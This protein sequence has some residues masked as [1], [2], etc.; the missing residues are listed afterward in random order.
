[1]VAV[2]ALALLWLHLLRLRFPLLGQ[3]EGILLAYADLILRGG[4]PNRDFATLYPP[5]AFWTVAAAFRLFGETLEVERGVG[6]LFQIS[7][8]AAVIQIGRQFGLFASLLAGIGVCTGVALFM[9]GAYSVLGGIACG[10]WAIALADI[11]ERSGG[12]LRFF[13]CGALSALAFLYRQ[14]A[15]LA[16]IAAIAPYLVARRNWPAARQYL[17]GFGAG[18][19]PL[20]LHALQAGVGPLFR[21][22]VLD[23]LAN[24]PGRALPIELGSLYP[25]LIPQ[26]AI[27][28]CAGLVAQSGAERPGQRLALALAL[29]SLCFLPSILQRAD[30]WHIGYGSIVLLPSAAI[31]LAIVG[32]G[33]IPFRLSGLAVWPI[34]PIS[35]LAWVYLLHERPLWFILPTAQ[36]MF[37]H[38]IGRF[39]GLPLNVGRRSVLAAPED[40][41]EHAAVAA[42]L[43]RLPAGARLVVGPTDLRR[44]MS[45]DPIF[46]FL[47]PQ[48]EPPYHLEMNP[49]VSDRQG[50]RLAADVAAADYLL[51]KSG[52]PEPSAALGSP[53]PNLL[54]HK[55]FCAERTLGRY[56]LLRRCRPSS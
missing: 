40:H 20:A 18:M 49:G 54:V 38:T 15:G 34:V 45:S 48:L 50:S 53:A 25:I 12:R 13:A 16:T 35:A 17:A 30:G 46:Y 37:G 7:I 4:V 9:P 14:D 21:N 29:F 8:L 43:A 27:L 22:Y 19:L 32:K 1:M 24:A 39:E 56:H 10:F 28:V 52:D 47:A 51:L 42:A 55:L 44:T 31:A 41:P 3:D 6:L 23:V 26:L 33:L 11:G 2:L 36:T 5:G